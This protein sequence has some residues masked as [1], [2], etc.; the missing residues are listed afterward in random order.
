MPRTGPPGSPTTLRPSTP[1]RPLSDRCA[2]PRSPQG[3]INYSNWVTTVSPS[4][5]DEA[6]NGGAAGWLREHFNTPA[7]RNKFSGVLNGI[8]TEE[9][10]PTTDSMLPATFS[11]ELPG[12]KALCKR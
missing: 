10:D 5:A 2:G 9:W 3:A 7:V 11:A 12:G 6:V 1:S 8:D 4:Y